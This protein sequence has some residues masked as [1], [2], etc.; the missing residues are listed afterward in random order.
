MPFRPVQ[1][2]KLRNQMA[3]P[4]RRSPSSA[5]WAKTVGDGVEQ[6]GTQVIGLD[7]H[8]AGRALELGEIVD[9]LDELFDI[10]LGGRS[11]HRPRL[12]STSTA[13]SPGQGMSST[14]PKACRLSM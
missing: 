14:R 2:E 1:V 3:I 12:A 9:Q 7:L 13:E 4:S 5:T 8:R 10:A 6:G 11:D